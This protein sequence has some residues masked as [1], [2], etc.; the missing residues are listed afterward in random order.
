MTRYY[1][2]PDIKAELLIWNGMFGLSLSHLLPQAVIIIGRHIK[3]M[4]SYIS[5]PET[6]AAA[7]KNPKL[8]GGPFGE[9]VDE[10][11]E[12]IAETKQRCADLIDLANVY[13]RCDA[14]LLGEAKGNCL[15]HFYERL[16]GNIKGLVELI[17]II[18]SE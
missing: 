12:L 17:I 9:K 1:L 4:E 2:Q 6:Y 5:A 16:P 7:V 3:I 13:K 14:M 8:L 11:K 18:G 10:V 15:E